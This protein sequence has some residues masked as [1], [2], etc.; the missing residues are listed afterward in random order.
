[1]LSEGFC[2]ILSYSIFHNKWLTPHQKL[3][4]PW[5]MN[6]H[7]SLPT[8]NTILNIWE[9]NCSEL[10]LC[11]I[12]M[13]SCICYPADVWVVKI[14][15][16]YSI[17]ELPNSLRTGPRI[18]HPCCALIL[19]AQSRCSLSAHLLQHWSRCLHTAIPAEHRAFSAFLS[20]LILPPAFLLTFTILTIPRHFDKLSQILPKCCIADYHQSYKFDAWSICKY[21]QYWR[22]SYKHQD[23][24]SRMSQPMSGP[25]F[26]GHLTTTWLCSNKKPE[27][28]RSNWHKTEAHR[29]QATG[30][31]TWK[32]DGTALRAL[33]WDYPSPRM[34]FSVPGICHFCQLISSSR[35]KKYVTAPQRLLLLQAEIAKMLQNHLI[36]YQTVIVYS[37]SISTGYNL[38]SNTNIQFSLS[39]SESWLSSSVLIHRIQRHL[40]LNL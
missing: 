3:S 16:E 32:T 26:P 36:I 18:S 19:V 28:M 7:S 10:G 25:S 39:R 12:T 34:G 17:L 14:P 30:P 5:F 20:P 21:L 8:V 2:S 23:G 27:D 38:Q 11:I 9:R 29:D 33:T 6:N 31:K 35:E 1:M 4:S 40:L 24:A 22:Y 15:R 37:F 13:I